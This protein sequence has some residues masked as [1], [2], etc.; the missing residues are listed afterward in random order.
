METR[1]YHK[2]NHILTPRKLIDA[3]VHEI[4]WIF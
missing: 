4:N 1:E 3:H 2:I